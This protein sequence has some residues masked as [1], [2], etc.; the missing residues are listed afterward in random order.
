M[1]NLCIDVGNTLTKV[2]V[3]DN[4]KMIHF[5][6]FLHHESW[7]LAELYNLYGVERA[8]I[9]S[10]GA[11]VSSILE[12]LSGLGTQIIVLDEKTNIPVDNCYETKETLGKDRLA[13]IVGASF[14]YP[15]TDLLVVDAGT[16]ITYDLINAAGQYLGGNISPGLQMRFSALNHYT[17]RLPLL[18]PETNYPLY[19]KNTTEA[20]RVGVQLGI[21]LEIDGT[22]DLYKQTYPNLKVIFTGGDIKYFD[23]KVKN[24]IFVISNLVMVGLNRILLYNA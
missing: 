11:D 4:Q 24:F 3:F 15:S 9:S 7:R 5:E 1:I 10:V 6:K 2:S 20:I 17:S 13:A 22:I 12:K 18:K 14:L 16:A 23:N 19:G 8:I 21:V